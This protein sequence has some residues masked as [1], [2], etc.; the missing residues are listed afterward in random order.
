MLLF[1]TYSYIFTFQKYFTKMLL[2]KVFVVIIMSITL[3]FIISAMANV[4]EF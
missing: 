4:L 2:K 1:Y 3:L